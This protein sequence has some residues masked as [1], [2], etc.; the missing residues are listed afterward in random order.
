MS[1][2]Q[3]LSIT[4]QTEQQIALDQIQTTVCI[5]VVMSSLTPN[6]VPM[7]FFGLVY[8]PP[9]QVTLILLHLPLQDVPQMLKWLQE[10]YMCYH[11]TC[12]CYAVIATTLWKQVNYCTYPEHNF[13]LSDDNNIFLRSCNRQWSSCSHLTDKMFSGQCKTFHGI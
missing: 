3:L 10:L 12:Q 8:I 9:D 7:F 4:S 11:V 1:K 6:K 13:A 5:S 2:H